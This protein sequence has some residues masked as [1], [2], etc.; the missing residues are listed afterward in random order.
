MDGNAPTVVEE[1]ALQGGAFSFTSQLGAAQ[2][3]IPLGITVD[4]TNNPSIAGLDFRSGPLSELPRAAPNDP[5][6]RIEIV[7]GPTVRLSADDLADWLA[8]I[9]L[10]QT[11][12][13]PITG[14]YL[15][16]A[17]VAASA[18]ITLAQLDATLAAGRVHLAAAGTARVSGLPLMGSLSAPFSLDVP[19][20][21][22]LPQ[23][24]DTDQVCDI[25]TRGTPQLDIGGPLGPIL[26]A[27]LPLLLNHVGGQAL[28]RLRAAL[29]EYLP[30]AIAAPFGLRALPAGAVPS[31]RRFEIT[32]TEITLAATIGAFGDL[33]STFQP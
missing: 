24:P 4:E 20:A 5:A 32:P 19:L 1:A 27:A 8:A 31:V 22:A 15:A 12:S 23:T 33:L 13:I 21:L 14:M 10:P 29:N 17:D 30:F 25:L 18:E 2:D 11:G 7:L 26:T 9:P 16:G 3:R 6:G 28:P